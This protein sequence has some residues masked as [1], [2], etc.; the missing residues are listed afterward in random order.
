MLHH[1]I[2]VQYYSD[3]DIFRIIF[4]N[5]INSPLI[6]IIFKFKDYCFY[7]LIHLFIIYIDL[8]LFIDL[9]LFIYFVK[10][11]IDTKKDQSLIYS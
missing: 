2:L 8:S 3:E 4:I 11:V 9:Q 7:C 1:I 6:V 5:I 10:V